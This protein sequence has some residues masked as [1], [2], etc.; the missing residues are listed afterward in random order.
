[1]ETTSKQLQHSRKNEILTEFA[2]VIARYYEMYNGRKIRTASEFEVLIGGLGEPLS[3]LTLNT[4]FTDEIPLF[5]ELLC[6]SRIDNDRKDSALLGIHSVNQLY[7][8]IN[9]D[10]RELNLFSHL[11]EDC[12]DA[13]LKGEIK[14]AL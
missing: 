11:V 14:P 9:R 6:K 10:K 4:E 3:N 8:S 1:M 12:W 2:E 7:Y 13:F 5:V